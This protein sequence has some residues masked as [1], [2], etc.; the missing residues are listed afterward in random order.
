MLFGRRRKF[1]IHKHILQQVES[2]WSKKYLT[3]YCCLI[4]KLV[5]IKIRVTPIPHIGN[6]VYKYLRPGYQ[7]DLDYLEEVHAYIQCN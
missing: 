7:Q 4:C 6:A 1:I 2:I 3:S 5:A